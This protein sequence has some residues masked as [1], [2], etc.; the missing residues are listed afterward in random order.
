[1]AID[2]RDHLSEE[3]SVPEADTFEPAQA[4]AHP[5]TQED[6]SLE[7]I[8]DYP[9]LATCLEA[10]EAARIGEALPSS[11]E[12]ADVPEEVLDYTMLLDYLPAEKDASVRMVGTYIGEKAAFQAHGMTVRAFFEERD[13]EIVTESL[14]RI[15][16]RRAPSL[17]RRSFVPIAGAPMSYVRL[18]LP[19][20]AN[21][22][23]VTG[24]FK[25]IEPSSLAEDAEA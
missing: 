3:G 23:A 12:V 2:Q 21:G 10:W 6:L 25:T 7:T 14:R 1:M 13:A 19:L 20:S 11:M 16:E 22:D 24:F 17:A 15:A 4:A 5:S 9:I 18:I 8:G